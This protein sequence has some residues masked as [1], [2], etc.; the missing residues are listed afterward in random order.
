[1]PAFPKP[2]HGLPGSGLLTQETI[3]S[4]LRK[5]EP[6]ATDHDVEAAL[7]R[8]LRGERKRPFDGDQQ[9]KTVTTGGGEGNYHPSGERGFTNREFACLQTFDVSYQ[10][11]DKEVRKQIGNAVPPVMAKAIYREIV[12]SL[13]RTDL[14]EAREMVQMGTQVDQ[15]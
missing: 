12:K 8:G 10:F 7:R 15:Y 4:I 6:G 5:I 13:K 14:A 9:A 1:M 3:N 11:G 2:T